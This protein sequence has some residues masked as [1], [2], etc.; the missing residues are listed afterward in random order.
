MPVVQLSCPGCGAPAPATSGTCVYCGATVEV[1][2]LRS[3]ADGA[4]RGG[5][6]GGP[7]VDVVLR[8]LRPAHVG[9][10]VEV[11]RRPPAVMA[12][13]PSR[14]PPV[15]FNVPTADAEALRARLAP[16]GVVVELLPPRGPGGQHGPGGPRGPGG[17]GG[18]RG[19]GGPGGPRGPG[20]PG[21]PRGPGRR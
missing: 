21:G 9:V 4:T 2:T 16:E 17:P 6:A 8:G 10:L 18:P 12:D 15:V 7:T 11:L 3:P 20:G 14:T 19:P 1:T 5:A 13:V